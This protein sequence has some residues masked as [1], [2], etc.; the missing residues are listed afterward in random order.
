MKLCKPTEHDGTEKQPPIEET[1]QVSNQAQNVVCGA[2]NRSEVG[3]TEHR[4][5][6]NFVVCVEVVLIG[7][8]ETVKDEVKERPC[9]LIP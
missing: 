4:E 8:L 3:V 9:L 2:C 5:A 6:S 1:A 7:K